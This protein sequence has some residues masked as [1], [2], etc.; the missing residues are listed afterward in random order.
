MHFL[1]VALYSRYS[2]SSQVLSHVTLLDRSN[3]QRVTSSTDRDFN[4]CTGS[5]KDFTFQVIIFM[6]VCILS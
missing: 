2:N 3:E 6:V 5:G 1:P 4:T